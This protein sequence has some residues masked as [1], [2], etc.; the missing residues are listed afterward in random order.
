MAAALTIVV[1][2]ALSVMII[3]IAGVAMR[4][5]GLA[6]NVARFQCISALTGTGYST[7]E[8][9]MIVNYP[10]RRRILVAVMVLGNLGMVSFAS[11]FIVA[12]IGTESEFEAII[13]QVFTMAGA[14]VVTLLLLTN[15]TLDRLMCDFIGLVLSK[16]TDL[17]TRHYQT[18]LQMDDGYSIVEHAFLDNEQR[19]LGELPLDTFPLQLLSIRKALG[20]GLC[21][22][23]DEDVPLVSGD[24][25]I[26][27]GSDEAHSKL[28]RLT[29]AKSE[30][31]DT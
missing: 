12:F 22:D 3:R 31:S 5:T 25:L 1:L 28:G 7:H 23:F 20:A 24:V 10:I 4:L 6:D 15:K 18:V 26:C 21:H 8:S 9:E 2:L 14:I 30:P 19:K 16:I 17:Q 13:R 29:I 11:T 27:Y